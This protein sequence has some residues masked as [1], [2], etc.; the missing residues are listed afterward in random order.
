ML[1]FAADEGFDGRIVE[2]LRLRVLDIDI[3]T[4]QEQLMRGAPDA[5]VLEWAASEDRI[6]LTHDVR[7]MRG[8]AY[9]RVTLGQRMPGV[10]ILTRPYQEGVII[11]DLEIVATASLE[12]EWENRVEYFPLP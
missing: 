10:F 5:D 4:V 11:G 1:R 7:T 9:D 6:L 12:G 2:G 3:V 8:F